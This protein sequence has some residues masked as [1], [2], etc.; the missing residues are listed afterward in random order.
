MLRKLL[1]SLT[2]ISLLL[3]PAAAAETAPPAKA[4]VAHPGVYSID[5]DP[6]RDLL[7]PA[8]FPVDGQLG[9]WLWSDLNPA[10]GKYD[11]DAGQAG[12]LQAWI[13]AHVGLGLRSAVMISTYDASTAN[14]I[15]ST[16][17]WVIK[18]PGATLPVTLTN[19]LPHY[20]DYYHRKRARHQN[21]EFDD[22]DLAWWTVSDGAA[23]AWVKTAPADSYVSATPDRPDRPAKGPALRLGG[24]NGM[25]ATIVHDPEAIPAMPPELNGKRNTFISARV[26]IVTS[27]PQPNDKLFMELWDERGN[28]LGGVE[29]AN[30]AH[31]GKGASF[32]GVYELDITPFALEKNV[33]VA[34]RVE[35]DGANLTTFYVDNVQ[36]RVRHLMPKYWTDP[37]L[38]AYKEFIDALGKRWRQPTAGEPW[39]DLEFV[40]MGTGVYGESQPAQDVK[41]WEYGTTF[42]HVVKE[43]GLDTTAEWQAFVNA[44]T[45]A[46]SKAFAAPDGTGPVKPL[47]LQYAPYF[48][49]ANERGLTAEFAAARGVGLSHNRLIPEWTQL[50][51]NNKTSAYDPLRLYGEQVPTAFEGVVS[52]LGCSPVLSYWSVVGAVARKTDYLRVDPALIS[53]TLTPGADWQPN[54]HAAVFQWAR[55]YLGKRADNTPRAW[56][57]MREQRNPFRLLCSQ[58]YYVTPDAAPPWAEYGNFDFYLAQD[59]TIPGGRTVAETNDKGADRRYAR[60]PNTGEAWTAAGMG[61]CPPKSYSAIYNQ[62]PPTCNPEPYNPNLPPLGGQ[63]VN[64]YK[65]FYN[66]YDWTG[67]GKEAWTVRR[68]DGATGNPFMFFRLDDGYIA[69]GETV[70]AQFTVGYFDIGTDKWALRYQSAGGEKVAGT[71]TKQGTRQYKEVTFTVTDAR[72]ANGLAGGADF[73]LDSRNDGDEWVHLVAVERVGGPQVTQ[74]PSPTVTPSVTPTVTPTGT[75]APPESKLF[76]P[77]LWR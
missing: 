57:I 36:L 53:T 47:L 52:D 63:N 37:Y 75:G 18:L 65:D 56:T 2:L 28:R 20:I 60:D 69:P 26:N 1:I 10:Q 7:D 16:P 34:F 77:L 8:K 38:S 50:Y 72:F 74:T 73:Y 46:H 31:A 40:A 44:V 12:R 30:T 19:G 51:K 24:A 27:D 66:P 17:N 64:D 54:A 23:I 4:R 22:S 35:T 61:N 42:D 41:E 55:E 5:Y 49:D 33:A 9:F 21:G 14:D 67:E 32:W 59:D 76:L 13:D 39:R 15:R 71:V 11:W 6:P 29:I 48:L 62:N 45:D 3:T 70:G 25:N 68:T 43:A 58:I